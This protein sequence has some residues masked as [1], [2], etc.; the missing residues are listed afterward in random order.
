[1][2]VGEKKYVE[3]KMMKNPATMCPTAVPSSVACVR[4]LPL[5]CT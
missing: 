2:T 4:S 5:V 3:N 1:M